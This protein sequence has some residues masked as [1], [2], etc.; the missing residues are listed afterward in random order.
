MRDVH[1]VYR[2][3]DQ[4]LHKQLTMRYLGEDEHGVW[5]GMPSGGL[6]HMGDRHAVT[7]PCAHVVLLPWDG[8]WTAWFNGEPH[9]M[10]IYCDVTTPWTWTAVDTVEAVDIDLDVARMRAEGSVEILDEDEFLHNQTRYSYPAE[11]V[12]E[13]RRTAQWLR[14]VLADGTEPFRHA[15]RPWASAVTNGCS[16]PAQP[17]QGRITERTSSGKGRPQPSGRPAAS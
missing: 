16:P 9:E 3:H 12:S 4:S 13:A 2:K 8:W 14:D 7:L 1:L 6:M 10:E 5:I 15:Y 11:L 17:P